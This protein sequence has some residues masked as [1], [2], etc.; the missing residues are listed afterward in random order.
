LLSWPLAEQRAFFEMRV[1]IPLALEEDSGKLFPKSN[2]ARDVRDGLV[3]IAREAGVDVRFGVRVKDVTP[4]TE[5][6]QGSGDVG[7]GGA[8]VGEGEGAGDASGGAVRT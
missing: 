7:G 1:G 3:R 5:G 8:R 6:E 4:A 2:R